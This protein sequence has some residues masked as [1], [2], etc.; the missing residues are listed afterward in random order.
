MV[1]SSITFLHDEFAKISG[2]NAVLPCEV[3]IIK[4]NDLADV[5]IV[6]H[7]IDS[8]KVEAVERS[9][10]HGVGELVGVVL[11]SGR[12]LLALECGDD[13]VVPWRTF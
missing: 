9:A 3:A 6:V 2:S 12:G 11:C 7:H 4:G 8:G 10:L 5:L 13:G 1:G